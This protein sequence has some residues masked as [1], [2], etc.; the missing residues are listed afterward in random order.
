MAAPVGYV[1]AFGGGVASFVSPCVL[2]VVPAYLSMVTGIDVTDVTLR[3]RGRHVRVARD[4]FLF[5]V[6]FGAV[7]V[8]IGISASAI[9]QA[10]LR[11]RIVLTE[12]SGVVVL[13]MAAFI[14]GTLVLR[15]PGLFR[16][17]RFHPSLSRLGPFAAPV[18]GAAFGFGWTPCIGPVL[19]SVTTVAA[20]ERGI[21]TGALLLACY[22][23]GLGVPFLLVGLGFSHLAG[24]LRLMRR[25]A[26]VVTAFSAVLLAFFGVLLVLNRLSFVT[27][28]LE[29]AMR[30]VGLGG[31]VKAG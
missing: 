19:A 26:G 21:G 25:Y 17:A 9:G 24:A 2:P 29:A 27:L 22:A 1:V 7:F 23:L 10:L 16:E 11:N 28:E 3:S 12:I 20:T 4:T 13:A 5:I 15:L 31:L 6:G 30:A 18:A 14:V 8:L